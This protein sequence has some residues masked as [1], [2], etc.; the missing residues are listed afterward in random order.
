MGGIFHHLMMVSRS[1]DRWAGGRTSSQHQQTGDPTGF[2]KLTVAALLTGGRVAGSAGTA[3]EFEVDAGGEACTPI[4]VCVNEDPDFNYETDV[5]ADCEPTMAH[6]PVL[7]GAPGVTAPGF[8]DSALGVATRTRRG[9]WRSPVQSTNTQP[10][11][12]GQ[13]RVPRTIPTT[14]AVAIRQ[15]RAG[16]Q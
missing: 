15:P 12:S 1:R 9:I 10:A 4:E 13:T 7:Q 2:N 6:R 8:E 14:P 5:A 3:L 16:C 11:T